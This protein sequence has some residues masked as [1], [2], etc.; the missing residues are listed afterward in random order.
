VSADVLLDLMLR[1]EEGGCSATPE[2]LCREHPNLVEEVRRQINSLRELDAHLAVVAS[3]DVQPVHDIETEAGPRPVSSVGP[4]DRIGPYQLV[5]LLGQGGMGEVWLA[6]QSEPVRRRVAVKFV[7]AGRLSDE[8]L[9]RFAAERQAL[10]LMDHPNIAKILEAGQ[11][12]HSAPGGFRPYFVMEFVAGVPITRYCDDERLNIRDR[13]GLFVEVCDAVQHAHQKGVIHRDLKPSNVLVANADGKPVPRVIDFG[14]AK[15]TGPRLTDE[16][17]VTMAGCPIG[18]LEYMAPEQARPNNLDVDTRA[19]VYALGVILYEL[20]TG[21]R[22][23]ES[24]E[25][26]YVEM[27]RLIREAEPPPPSRRFAEL[28][29]AADVAV[30][31]GTEPKRLATQLRG[32][33][34]WIALK[35]LEKAR[36]QRFDSAAALAADLRRYLG[37]EPVLAGPPSRTYRLRKFVR[38]NKGAVAAVGVIVLA[39]IGGIAATSWQAHKAELARRDA[40]TAGDLAAAREKDAKTQAA[41]ARAVSNFLSNDVLVLASAEGRSE[42][43]AANLGRNP[44]VRELLD[45]AAR[46]IDGR[47]PDQPLVEAEIRHTIGRAYRRLGELKLALPHLERTVALR[48]EVLGPDDPLTLNSQQ[49]LALVYYAAGNFAD[50][51]KMFEPIVA[52]QEAKL[53]PNHQETLDTLNNLAVCNAV[54]K[55]YPA[56]IRLF[57][58]VR[59]RRLATAGAD[60]MALIATLTNLSGVYMEA[61]RLPEAIRASE[62]TV[63]TATAKLG[64]RHPVTLT[65]LHNLGQIYLDD[66]RLE[67]A[68]RVGRQALDG[69]ISVHGPDHPDTLESMVA[70]ASAHAKAGELT[71]AI[72]LYEKARKGYDAKLP[73]THPNRLD[74]LVKL[75]EVYLG[76]DRPADAE[77]VLREALTVG[78][79]VRPDDPTTFET[80]SL[81][82]AALA[83]QHKDALAESLLLA[84]CQGLERRCAEAGEPSGRRIFAKAID[85]LVGF[86]GDRGRQAEAEKWRVEGLAVAG[87]PSRPR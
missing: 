41:V 12:S 8:V 46:R 28:A 6:Q 84:G 67:D 53:G 34:D 68:V 63:T 51:I 10:A 49:S 39:L 44:T 81:L 33:L 31:R 69:R 87:D 4:G 86:Y 7:R 66:G 43:G 16:T 77:T 24:G 65:A 20:L 54:L 56:A 70:L 59:D 13:L 62:Q 37:D 45:R 18:T 1:W 35:C 52:A 21:G 40:V 61:G 14:I 78:E 47:F 85:R 38:R 3:T 36:S 15:T 82:G 71:I 26:D 29:D 58:I 73:T 5:S 74:A 79:K 2:E 32:D 72:D 22:P 64:P 57:E 11:S 9:A 17:I 19:D 27:I 48:K 83:A 76:N 25:A 50:A 60:D 42:V 30:R 55:N 75:G 80:K 23:F